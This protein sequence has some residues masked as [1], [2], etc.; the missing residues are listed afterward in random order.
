MAQTPAKPVDKSKPITGPLTFAALFMQVEK[1]SPQAAQTID[2]WHRFANE[3]P[4]AV[5]VSFQQI[6]DIAYKRR[7]DLW[8]KLEEFFDTQLGSG[9]GEGAEG[10]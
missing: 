9:T 5:F 10:R 7:L 6:D 4:A 1:I 8:Q 2:A 3:P